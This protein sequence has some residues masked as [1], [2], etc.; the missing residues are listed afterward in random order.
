MKL[1]IVFMV[2]VVML[3]ASLMPAHAVTGV[4][5]SWYGAGDVFSPCTS[6]YHLLLLSFTGVT[7]DFQGIDLL[8]AI[9]TDGNGELL[10][11][12]THGAGVGSV[13][14]MGPITVPHG[15]GANAVRDMTAR[16]IT[17]RIY[18]YVGFQDNITEE[19]VYQAVQGSP[20][21]AEI[22][23]D[24]ALYNI[25]CGNFPFVV[26]NANNGVT[27]PTLGGANVVVA[28]VFEGLLNAEFGLDVWGIDANG[29]G[30][31]AFYVSGETLNSLP[32]LPDENLL[33]EAT[34]DGYI[35]LYRLTTGEYQIN[36]GPD[37]EGN[38]QVVIFTGIPPS[39]I[40]RRDFNIYDILEGGG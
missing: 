24:P 33:I 34:A 4:S 1:Y 25:D 8:A 5:L 31:K 35:A 16:P 36:I 2:M 21:L 12:I 27:P 38:V 18:E 39:N 7:D 20:V 26:A 22:T 9:S 30:F 15:V 14:N 13:S 11:G 6:Q 32:P 29:E 37:I 17:T 28:P 19:Q 23:Y 3:S 40:Y 10:S